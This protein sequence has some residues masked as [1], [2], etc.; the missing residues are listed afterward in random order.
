MSTLTDF[1]RTSQGDSPQRQPVQPTLAD[2]LARL[3][4]ANLSE[5]RRREVASDVRSFCRIVEL[6][7][8]QVLA[9][10][11]DLRP[12]L[13]RVSPAAKTISRARWF[14][15]LSGLR[16]ALQLTGA[17]Q[18]T[19][20]LLPRPGPVWE[21]LLILISIAKRRIV[22][23]RFARYCTELTITPEQVDDAIIRQ[24]RF[25]LEQE[26]FTDPDSKI[27]QLCRA[28]NKAAASIPA[29]PQQH[30]TVPS[31]LIRYT[32]PWSAYP[33]SLRCEVEQHLARCLAPDPLDPDAPA[34]LRAS[35]IVTRRKLL[36]QLAAARV[37][38]GTP[39]GEIRSLADI[40]RPAQL[41][42]ALTFFLEREGCKL[43][44]LMNRAVVARSIARHTLRLPDAELAEL[45]QICTEISTVGCANSRQG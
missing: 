42:D 3:P 24:F 39:P 32:L 21:E 11:T 16:R 14:N 41:R 20:R 19:L 23:I 44:T 10:A 37:N 45:D 26:A 13:Q 4:N 5:R 18:S 15:I 33:E 17:L 34:P 30:L 25:A 27:A 29:W 40:V 36:R 43:A 35:T 9:T 1:T 12:L 7:A 38:R 28:W 2:V 31:R 8:N 22:F 6:P